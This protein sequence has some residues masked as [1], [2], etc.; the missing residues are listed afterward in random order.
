MGLKAGRGHPTMPAPLREGGFTDLPLKSGEASAWLRE[1]LVGGSEGDPRSEDR[2]ATHSCKATVLSWMSKVGIDLPSRRLAG[3]HTDGNTKSALEYSRD[4]QAPILQLISD[5]FRIMSY[6]LFHPDNSRSG[7]FVGCRD[8]QHALSVADQL[9]SGTA[10]G[11]TEP[12]A[13]DVE[14][15]SDPESESDVSSQASEVDEESA[16]ERE[17]MLA[18]EKMAAS[19]PHPDE[20]FFQDN[21]VLQHV[22][23]KRFHLGRGEEGPDGDVQV[24][25]CGRVLSA[26]YVHVVDPTI[27]LASKCCIC[28]R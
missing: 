21:R 14:A 5:L 26:N 6:G 4:A 22:R 1:L 17:G 13:E 8:F 9:E 28:F 12:A 18:A 2:L 10:E 19:L 15:A 20:A 7:R 3:Y 25:G 27:F 16:D 11:R 24:T 23:T